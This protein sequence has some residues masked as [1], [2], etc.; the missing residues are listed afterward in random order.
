MKNKTKIRIDLKDGG[1][2]FRAAGTRV[3]ICCEGLDEWFDVPHDVHKITLVVSQK[4]GCDEESVNVY[5]YPSVHG[6]ADT[7]DTY[8]LTKDGLL[9]KLGVLDATIRHIITQM[10]LP[11]QG[12]LNASIE[13]EV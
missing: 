3:A 11:P 12:V 1:V 6:H 9:G 8:G 5:Y 4:I 7:Y 13:Y 10:G 2:F